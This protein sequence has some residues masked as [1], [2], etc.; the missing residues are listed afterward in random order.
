MQ[1]KDCE[2]WTYR[3]KG[4]EEACQ[5]IAMYWHFLDPDANKLKRKTMRNTDK[6][7]HWLD[8]PYLIIPQKLLKYDNDIIVLKGEKKSPCVSEMCAEI[9]TNEIIGCQGSAA[10]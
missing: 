6:S 7:Q 5:S 1:G 8:I 9:L 3:F 4:S 2:G 10:K